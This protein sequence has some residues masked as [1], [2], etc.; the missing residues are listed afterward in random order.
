MRKNCLTIFLQ[1]RLIN[2]M[3][4]EFLAQLGTIN[5]RERRKNMCCQGEIMSDHERSAGTTSVSEAWSLCRVMIPSGSAVRAGER[6]NS[7][8]VP[9]TERD[10]VRSETEAR[11]ARGK[12]LVRVG[13]KHPPERLNPRFVI[14][15]YKIQPKML[16]TPYFIRV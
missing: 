6:G 14:R 4:S 16:T 15:G 5:D 2:G 7:W 10:G 12:C 1:M 3:V 9:G 8:C 11:K 13:A